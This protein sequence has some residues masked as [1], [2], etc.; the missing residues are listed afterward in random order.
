MQ[1]LFPQIGNKWKIPLIKENVE[2]KSHSQRISRTSHLIT[3]LAYAPLTISAKFQN[4]SVM[5]ISKSA[6]SDIY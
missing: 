2:S 6:I 5:D 1:R 3:L 4:I